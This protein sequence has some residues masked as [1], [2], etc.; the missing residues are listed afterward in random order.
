MLAAVRGVAVRRHEI[1][2]VAIEIDERGVERRVRTQSLGDVS[3][4]AHDGRKLAALD[5][6]AKVAIRLIRRLRKERKQGL[7]PPRVCGLG[8]H[9]R[10]PAGA[11]LNLS[12]LPM[13]AEQSAIKV[14]GGPSLPISDK[15]STTSLPAAAAVSVHKGANGESPPAPMRPAAA[16]LPALPSAAASTD[17]ATDGKAGTAPAQKADVLRLDSACELRAVAYDQS[18]TK[19]VA[20]VDVCAEAAET[21]A[22]KS[23]SRPPIDLALVVDRSGSMSSVMSDVQLT[24]RFVVEQLQETDRLAIVDFDNVVSTPVPLT[25][26]TAAAKRDAMQRIGELHARGGTDLCAG[27]MRG[28]E[29]LRQRDQKGRAATVLL[30]TDGEATNG[31]TVP[32]E[33]VDCMTRPDY[34]ARRTNRIPIP[35]PAAAYKPSKMST[36]STSTSFLYDIGASI[37]SGARLR[38]LQVKNERPGQSHQHIPPP[39]CLRA[40]QRPADQRRRSNQPDFQCWRRRQGR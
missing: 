4:L 9:V 5:G 6:R 17:G 22:A 39:R 23:A 16:A 11:L 25:A 31:I 29:I 40:N 14:P 33:I 19:F 1:L 15:S 26:M 13:S 3:Q 32:A 21:E 35:K 36:G 12:P 38:P 37:V 7:R 20:L 2:A 34:F 24:L 30:L 18:L 27:L 8:I 10:P 28:L